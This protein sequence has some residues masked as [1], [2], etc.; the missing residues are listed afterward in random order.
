[1]F[2]ATPPVRNYA[3]VAA[4][5]ALGGGLFVAFATKLIPRM[6]AEMRS[7]MMQSMMERMG[8]GGCSP[9]EM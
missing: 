6:M 9:A 5:G 7:G 2:T 3:L 8:Q 1:M 4:L